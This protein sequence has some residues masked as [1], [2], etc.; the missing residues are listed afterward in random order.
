MEI[1]VRSAKERPSR[2][3]LATHPRRDPRR[4]L[5]DVRQTKRVALPSD[6]QIPAR[7][8]M[9]LD[10]V[11]NPLRVLRI[12]RRCTTGAYRRAVCGERDVVDFGVAR[13]QGRGKGHWEVIRE[14]SELAMH[15]IVGS[16]LRWAAC[17]GAR[18]R[19][20]EV[21]GGSVVSGGLGT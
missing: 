17:W 10:C 16:G 7:A 12:R 9:S 18:G 3:G 1:V 20:V 19:R 11:V 2:D 5:E 21:P 15:A 13:G 14:A 6:I 4:A 8:S